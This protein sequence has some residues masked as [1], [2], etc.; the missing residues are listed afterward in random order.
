MTIGYLRPVH[1]QLPYKTTPDQ[2]TGS[3][4]LSDEDLRDAIGVDPDD[5]TSSQLSD[6]YQASVA[7][8]NDEI[9]Q[10]VPYSTWVSEYRYARRRFQLD[11]PALTGSGFLTRVQYYDHDETLQSAPNADWILDSNDEIVAFRDHPNWTLS[12][13]RVNPIRISYSSGIQAHPGGLAV[14]K[15]AISLIAD[16]LYQ[17]GNLSKPDPDIMSLVRKITS[18][19]KRPSI[20]G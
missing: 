12:D 9:E 6:L 20:N 19:Y 7:I 4:I 18:K 3:P 14:A 11:G 17:V 5:I 15:R 8:L 2:Y 13:S 10:S 16:N 1:S